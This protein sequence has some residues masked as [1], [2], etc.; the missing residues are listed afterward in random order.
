MTHQHFKSLSQ[1]KKYRNLLLNGVCLAS[2][3]TEE[4]CILLFQLHD[5]YVEI[6]FDS[7]CDE[8]LYSR[9]FQNTEELNPFLEHIDISHL[10]DK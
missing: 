9:S 1:D 4:H 3:D 5:F 7:N 10:T 2:R 6:Y 8:I